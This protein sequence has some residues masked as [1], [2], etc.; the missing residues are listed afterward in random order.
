MYRQ[1]KNMNRKPRLLWNVSN[2]GR[3]ETTEMKSYSYDG[4]TRL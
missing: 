3:L 4:V 2:I 1:L